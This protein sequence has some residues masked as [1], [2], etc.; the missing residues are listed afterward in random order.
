[1]FEIDIQVEQEGEQYTDLLRGAIEATLQHEQVAPPASVV[2]LL[3]DDA[4][5]RQ[6]NLTYRGYDKSTDVLSFTDG[7]APF[8]DAPVHL[9]DIAISLPQ[10]MRQADE[11]KGGISAE[12]QLLATHGTLHLL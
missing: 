2:L 9:G 3:T 1:M 8:P 5:L 7:E 6:L 4:Q 10:A 11:K 12:L